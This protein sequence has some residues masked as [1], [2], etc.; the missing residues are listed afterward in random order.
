[1]AITLN[2][3]HPKLIVIYH[4]YKI[5][6]MMH[7]HASKIMCMYMY[8]YIIVV[9]I[10]QIYMQVPHVYITIYTCSL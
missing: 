1:M 5:I 8:S 2:I 9:T 10:I 4:M 7:M 6:V 3:V